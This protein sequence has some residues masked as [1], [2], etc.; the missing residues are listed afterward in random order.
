M[1]ASLERSSSSEDD[2]DDHD[3][4]GGGRRSGSPTKDQR[5]SASYS[6]SPYKTQRTLPMRGTVHA[7]AYACTYRLWLALSIC[8]Y[9]VATGS[10]WLQQARLRCSFLRILDFHSFSQARALRSLK[11][12]WVQQDCPSWGTMMHPYPPSHQALCLQ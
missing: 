10:R 11:L 6:H 2:N 5:H 3:D 8:T 1:V 7:Y 4:E 9:G 12:Q